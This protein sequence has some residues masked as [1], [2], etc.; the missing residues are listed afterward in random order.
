MGRLGGRHEV[1]ARGDRRGEGARGDHENNLMFVGRLWDKYVCTG[2]RGSGG[3]TE[4][5]TTSIE[6]NQER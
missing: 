1:R 2:K 3:Q 6:S 4:T 5:G